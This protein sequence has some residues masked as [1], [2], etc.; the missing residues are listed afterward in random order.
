[1]KI[2][3][4]RTVIQMKATIAANRLTAVMMMVIVSRTMSSHMNLMTLVYSLT[5]S[6]RMYMYAIFLRMGTIATRTI[7]RV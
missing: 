5:N 6:I 1:M 3:Y 7:A 2:T 4:S